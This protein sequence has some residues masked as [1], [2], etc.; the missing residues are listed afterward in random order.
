MEEDR[1]S[2]RKEDK[3][4]R[5]KRRKLEKALKLQ[6]AE[7]EF[8]GDSTEPPSSEAQTKDQHLDSDSKQASPRTSLIAP[9]DESIAER[10][11]DVIE[12][13][14]ITPATTQ[15]EDQANAN[16]SNATE[17][18][19]H[20]VA[21]LNLEDQQHPADAHGLTQPLLNE[22]TLRSLMDAQYLQVSQQIDSLET[23]R[24]ALLP[25]VSESV[26][27]SNPKKRRSAVANTA[28]VATASGSNTPKEKKKSGYLIF[29]AEM[30]ARGEY[31][32]RS[33]VDEKW[34]ALSPEE[35]L[36]WNSRATSAGSERSPEA[37]SSTPPPVSPV[38]ERSS[39]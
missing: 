36:K 3:E 38:P 23:F 21:S 30:K 12:K 16:T 17:A 33:K 13:P 7:K 27:V 37:T 10:I 9:E 15:N 2:K 26:R 8:E 32:G 29:L 22:A 6:K 11:V 34:R 14:R 1:K 20:D 39:N 25:Y 18:A 5:R 28:A 35:K 31:E 4:E 19:S 24:Q